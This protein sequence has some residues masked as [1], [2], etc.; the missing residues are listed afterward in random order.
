MRARTV[1]VGL[2]LA[3]VALG[4]DVAWADDVLA[5]ETVFAPQS[6]INFLHEVRVGAYAHNLIHDE[7]S[8]VDVSVETLSS[9][10]VYRQYRRALVVLVFRSAHQ[11]RRD[12]Q[13]RGQDE[14]RLHR[15]YLA[16]PIY[17]GLFFEGEFGGAVNTSPMRAEPDRVDMGCCPTSA[18]PAASATSPRTSDLIVNIEHTRTRPLHHIDPGLTQFGARVGYKF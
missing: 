7:D 3:C 14:L 11:Y 10:I 16:H 13:H 5:P 9:P 18:N 8:P 15:P 6:Y 2:G 1:A 12:D 4:A 17:R